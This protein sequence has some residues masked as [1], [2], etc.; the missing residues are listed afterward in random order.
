MTLEGSAPPSWPLVHERDDGI[1]PAGPPDACCYCLQKVGQPHGAE[2]VVVTKTVEVR[3][4]VRISAKETVT[5]TFTEE[6]PY[7]WEEGDCVSHWV[8]SSLC[9]SNIMT[10]NIVWSAADPEK[11]WTVLRQKE[12]EDPCMCRLVGYEDDPSDADT[13]IRFA[14]GRVVDAGPNRRIREPEAS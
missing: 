8:E 3:V 9:A 10:R 4:M 13:P 7:F 5:G 12:R 14:F 6:N 2:C 11:I 1:R